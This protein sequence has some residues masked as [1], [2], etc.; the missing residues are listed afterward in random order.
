MARSGKG[1]GLA[2]G[3][4]PLLLLVVAGCG[5]GGQAAHAALPNCAGTEQSVARPDA[6]P[7][8]IPL[9]PGTVLRKTRNEGGFVVVNGVAPGSLREARDYVRRAF[10]KAGYEL[11]GGDAEENE[12]ETEFS[13]HGREGRL[14]LHTL[15]G[16]KGAVTVAVAVRG[17]S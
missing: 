9:P 16:C 14:K 1:A 7:A 3:V 4:G 8:G 12:A 17:G 10:P 11:G 6:F 2:V 13:G 15:A 5:G